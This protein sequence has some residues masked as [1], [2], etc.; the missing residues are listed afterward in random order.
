MNNVV[1]QNPCKDSKY[2]LFN[3]LNKSLTI[4]FSPFP[5]TLYCSTVLT[6][7]ILHLSFGVQVSKVCLFILFVC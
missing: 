2:N 3:P 5:K 4:T 6:L 7:K 1:K